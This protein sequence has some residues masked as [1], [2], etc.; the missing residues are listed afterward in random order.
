MNYNDFIKK[1]KELNI[2][3][4]QI[5]EKTTID[6]SVEIIDGHIE[7]YDD[8]NNIDYEIKAEYNG[9]TVKLSTTYLNDEIL[10]LIIYKCLNTDTEYKDD[11]IKNNKIIK[12][13]AIPNFT[14]KEEIEKIKNADKIRDKY[15][16]INK[17]TIYFSETY[18]NTRIINS[19]G[20]DISTDSHLSQLIVETVV[21]KEDKFTSYDQKI[22]T[23]DKKEINIEEFVEDVVKKAIL[24]CEKEKLETNKFNIILDSA[25]SSRIVSNLA[26]ML[27]ATNIRNKFS[28]LE[29]K[30]NKKVFS[31]KLTIIEDPTN[32]KYPG[33]RLFDDEGTETYKKSIVDSGKIA[34]FLYNIKEAMI[35]EIS[36]T[37]NGYSGI[38]TKNM[39]VVPGELSEKDLIKKLD[40]GLYITD[41]MGAS[42]TSI[43]SVNGDISLQIFGFIVE[44]GKIKCGFEPCIM[45]TT[46]FELLSNIDEIGKDLKFT[47]TS[48][49]SP[50]LLI[51]D[52][53]IAG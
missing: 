27:S 37:G 4:I 1:A 29:N 22:L 44:N 17:L 32:K 49:A 30:L 42:G 21:K 43:N 2:S 41:Y 20:I 35:N 45:T 36:S 11:Y 51:K 5:A 48:T 23:T 10:E 28:C 15:K 25:V 12:K 34:T 7:S 6:S 13:N 31:D 40:N 33:Y 14:I 39:Y 52:I 3:N 46:I 18:K 24:I 16:E 19:N 47:M 26:T 9:K 38:S 50:L 53:S 8:Y